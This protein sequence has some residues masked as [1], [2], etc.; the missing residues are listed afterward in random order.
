M[1]SPRYIYIHKKLT[2]KVNPESLIISNKKRTIPENQKYISCFAPFNHLRINRSGEVSPCCFSTHRERWKRGSVSLR[3]IWFKGIIT[4]YQEQMINELEH[5][6][7]R[8][9]A[10]LIFF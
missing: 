10:G 6:V 1:S 2:Q 7:I 8:D 4:K 9:N 3:E 5:I